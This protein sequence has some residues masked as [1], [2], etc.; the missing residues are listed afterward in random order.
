MRPP[1]FDLPRWACSLVRRFADQEVLDS[2][3]EDLETRCKATAVT[4]G[5]VPA[6]FQ[7]GLLVSIV[8]ISFLSE[9][10]VWRMTMMGSYLKVAL[11][12][13]RRRKI[14]SFINIVG[15]ALGLACF[16]LIGLWVKDELSFDR[17][18]ENKDRIFRILNRLD[19]GT[20]SYSTTYALGPALKSQYAE[21]EEACRV[22]PWFGSL[23]KHGDLSFMEYD[24]ALADP[25]FFK[26][27]SFPLLQGDPETVLEDQF[28]V[29]L[30]EDTAHRYFGSEDPMG[31][32]L[33]I[34]SRQG[35]FRVTGVMKNVPLN[36]HLQFDIVARI[37]FLGR[38]RLARWNEMSGPNY[39]LLEPG[40]EAS[41]FEAK[42]ADIYTRNI[43]PDQTY[44]PV[45]QSLN[46]VHLFDYTRSAFGAPNRFKRVTMFSM[47]AIFILFMACI[48]FMNLAT[49]QSTKR[50]Q[51]VGLRK[52]VGALRRQVIR[53]FLGEAVL[54]AFVSL[55]LALI[56][57]ESV[58]PHFNQ[59]TGKAMTLLTDANLTLVLV[60]FLVTLSTGILAGSYPALFLSAFQPAMTLKSQFSSGNRGVRIRK[61]LIVTQFA[62]S[63]GLIVCT[64]IVS[65]QLRFIQSHDLGVDR[66]HVI[67]FWNN[68]SLMIKY[69]TF[70]DNLLR[71][72]GVL[73]VTAGAQLPNEVG[74]NVSINWDG[75]PGLDMLS[76]DYSVVDYDFFQTFDMP[77]IQGRAFSREF[78]TDRTQACVINETAAALMGLAD[79]VGSRLYLAHPGWEESFRNV[80]VIGV[81]SDFHS[82]S[83]HTLIRPFF[84]RMYKPWQQYVFVKIAGT[85][86][87][88]ALERIKNAYETAA[89][90]YPFAYEFLDEAFERQYLPEQRMGQLFNIFSLI[91]ITIACLGLFGLASYT[92]EQKTKEIGIR[93]VLGASV[94][95][96]VKLTV[97]GFL[98]WIALANFLAWPLSYYAMSLWLTEFAY[99]VDLGL[100]PFF[101]AAGLT[102]GIALLTVSFHALKAALSNPIQ[103]LRYE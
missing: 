87:P 55:A 32:V 16:I 5:H 72:P 58:L 66:D 2:V 85:Q 76:A 41:E 21:V 35:D 71:E 54:I 79:P 99:R 39:I 46:Q 88:A 30:S 24:I 83:L 59:F 6:R 25:S 50:A 84:F 62:I 42:I 67:Y 38:A 12:H 80:H 1:N 7:W 65:S 92:V 68:P 89:P 94:F 49:A 36:S 90:G 57:V 100:S 102:L 17:F 101:L 60:L 15:L 14:Y 47:I 33:H 61:A 78:S 103:S 73:H 77:I 3:T 44:V 96:L 28:S 48:N 19:N 26:M 8:V 22:W 69:E 86:I 93:K 13:I 56:L 9:Y 10:M 43:G 74:Q 18:H 45:L 52:V 20:A 75:N 91:S 51:E 4:S 29:V 97:R 40:T 95:K 31:K 27:F 98:K 23:V 64:L 53:Q 37:E 11:R 70:K 81:V 34:T 63:V 82:R